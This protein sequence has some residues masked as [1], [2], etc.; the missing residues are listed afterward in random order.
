MSTEIAESTENTGKD[1]LQVL[2]NIKNRLVSE[3][4][5]LSVR[6]TRI[7]DVIEYI[8]GEIEIYKA[9]FIGKPQ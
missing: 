5:D 4:G 6:T 2:T 7:H 3:L 1:A 8:D 9:A